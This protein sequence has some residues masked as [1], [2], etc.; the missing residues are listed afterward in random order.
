MKMERDLNQKWPPNM[1][2]LEDLYSLLFINLFQKLS[3]LIRG[4]KQDALIARGLNESRVHLDELFARA[5]P[6]R[7]PVTQCGQSR[8][9]L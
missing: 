6:H 8:T 7:V 1:S 5:A 4:F 2:K 3:N 9:L